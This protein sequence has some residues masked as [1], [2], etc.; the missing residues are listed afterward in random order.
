MLSRIKY[1]YIRFV[2]ALLV[3]GIGLFFVI[4]DQNFDT[5]YNKAK[6][7]TDIKLLQMQEGDKI[8]QKIVFDHKTVHSI[9][10]SI[11]NR[12]NACEGYIEIALLDSDG[13]EIWKEKTNVTDFKLQ[14]V[15]W[16]RLKCDVIEESEYVLCIS[17]QE[18]T[19]F[20]QFAGVDSDY[21]AR[22]VGSAV[23]TRDERQDGLSLFVE[24]TYSKS[25]DKKSRVII[26]LWTLV[27]LC[28]ICAFEILYADK[29][30]RMITIFS[31]VDL[32]VI[33]A[34]FKL[35]IDFEQVYN[36]KLFAVI[37]IAVLIVITLSTIMLVGGCKK[38]E[39]YF[40]LY[41]AL[42]GA[43]YT[44]LLPPFSAPDED[45]HYL[46]AY[47]LS[48]VIM[49]NAENDRK[50]ITFM[51]ECDAAAHET[52]ITNEYFCDIISKLVS[53][54]ED[55]SKEIIKVN[56]SFAPSVP[57]VMYLPQA[58]G[59]S[60]GRLLYVNGVQLIYCGRLMNLMFFTMLTAMAIKIMPYGKWII[61]AICQIPIV[62][63]LAAS[64]SYD[65]IVIAL[66]FFVVAYL[67]KMTVQKNRISKKELAVLAAI[68]TVYASLKPVYLPIVALVFIIP[69]RK[70]SDVLWKSILYKTGV[71]LLSVM[72][73]GAVYKGLW[74]NMAVISNE[75]IVRNENYDDPDDF[76]MELDRDVQ[77]S[78]QDHY[79]HPNI[80]FIIENPFDIVESYAGAV[81]DLSDEWVFSAFGK[82]LSWYDVELPTYVT[83]TM[84]LLAY[85]SFVCE[86]YNIIPDMDRF[87]RRWAV[88][89]MFG[90]WVAVLL[91]SYLEWTNPSRKTIL[92]V[93]G[94]YFIPIFV[95]AI[96]L[97][98]GK[99][100]KKEDTDCNIVMLASFV[101]VMALMGIC[102]EIWG[103]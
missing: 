39:M 77:I 3:L 73:I 76:V 25:L 34:Y 66:T 8:E 103:R 87:K 81:I 10:I 63:E 22:G 21:G 41:A 16:Y 82:Y 13:N 19:G 69:G 54:K 91:T 88:L 62:V 71:F 15:Q 51:R 32:T 61:F 28:H 95:V 53:G 23:V 9:G 40:I 18:L 84:M 68:C 46:A 17:A 27:V 7:F 36:Y 65:A 11:V 50:G 101:N 97:L 52:Y 45:R 31:L 67:L 20:I 35:G 93:Q 30:R 70:I 58:L 4:S 74:F 75:R 49:M 14:R 47:R 90:C 72:M 42:F 1:P 43:M 24:M 96:F 92:G 89:M 79:I 5:D 2:L 83:I 78:D 100:R 59:I 38:I 57:V 55:L 6:T 94:R 64:C 26:L 29:R 86:D 44:I 60:L 12:T 85:I 98:Q 56:N 37:I 48:N 102:S 99:H 33:S 80:D